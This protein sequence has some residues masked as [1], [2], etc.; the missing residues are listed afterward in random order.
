VDDGNGH[1][2]INIF[3]E[4]ALPDGRV[5]YAA[6]SIVGPRERGPAATAASVHVQRGSANT[7]TMHTERATAEATATVRCSAYVGSRMECIECIECMRV[8]E[9]YDGAE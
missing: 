4:D 6:K 9:L 1:A 5:E 7:W 8:D 3:T 2:N